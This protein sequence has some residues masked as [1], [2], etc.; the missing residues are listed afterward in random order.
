MYTRE[1]V[2]GPE[3]N[4]FTLI[5]PWLSLMGGVFGLHAA[6]QWGGLKSVLGKCLIF[7]AVGLLFQFFGQVAYAYYIYIQGIE[8]PYPSLGDIGY[9]GS[10]IFYIIGALYLGKVTGV[11]FRL[12]SYFVRFQAVIIPLVLLLL[13][14]IFFLRGYELDSSQNLRTFLD[15]A[16]PFG[17]AIYVSIAISVILI[18]RKILGGIM[19]GPIIFILISL[20]I[21]YACDFVFLYQASQGTWYVGGVN[22]FMY[23]V[24]YFFM[25]LSLI[26]IHATF[27]ELESEQN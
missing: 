17:Q 2:E 27:K 9:F 1:L 20:L 16:Y 19:K 15:F 10:V 8:V 23:F 24:S 3:N 12:K 22:D 26:Y 4:A 18:S 5:Y 11:K 14:Y 13:S 7:L 21:Q 25:T 6:R